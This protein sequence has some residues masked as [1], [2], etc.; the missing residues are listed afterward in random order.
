MKYAELLKNPGPPVEVDDH[1]PAFESHLF[2]SIAFLRGYVPRALLEQALAEKPDGLMFGPRLVKRDLLSVA[3]FLEIMRE[4]RRI[5]VVCRAC[6]R[7]FLDPAEKRICPACRGPLASPTPDTVAAAFGGKPTLAEKI[8]KLGRYELLETLGR[9]GMGVVYKARDTYLHRIVALKVLR[10]DLVQNAS[11]LKRFI[12]E[13]RNAARLSH[14]NIVA[15]YE[16]EELEGFHFMVMQYVEGKTLDQVLPNLSLNAKLSLL[17]RVARAVHYAHT[18]GVVHRD[19]KPQNIMVDAGMNPYVMDFGLSK[20]EEASLLL[21][22][23][24]TL[25]G[26]PAYMSPEQARGQQVDA[27]S[28]VYS[29]GVMLYEILTGTLPHQHDSM[30]TLCRMIAEQDP[31]RPRVLDSRIPADLEAVCLRALEKDRNLRYPSAQQLADDLQRFLSNEP[32]HA[33]APSSVRLLLRRMRRHRAVLV[34]F[35]TI[36]ISAAVTAGVLISTAHEQRRRHQAEQHLALAMDLLHRMEFDS[37]DPDRRHRLAQEAISQL[38]R[39]LQLYAAYAAA[40]RERG[41]GKILMGLTSEGLSDLTRAIELDP[42]S[43]LSYF[44][45]GRAYLAAYQKTKRLPVLQ[46]SPGGHFEY[47]PPKPGEGDDLRRAALD[48][49]RAASRLYS[50]ELMQWQDALARGVVALYEGKYEEARDTLRRAAALFGQSG[51]TQFYLGCTLLYLRSYQEA[52]T[53][54]SEAL[55]S[56]NPPSNAFTFRGIA[57]L[58]AWKSTPGNKTAEVLQQ[59][60]EDFARALERSNDSTAELLDYMALTRLELAGFLAVDPTTQLYRADM[61]EES[62]KTYQQALDAIDRAIA[63][64][65][66]DPAFLLHK[67]YICGSMAKL[68]RDLTRQEE[69]AQL[70]DR[71]LEAGKKD[72]Y[73]FTVAGNAWADFGHLRRDNNLDPT[74]AYRRAIDL[75]TAALELSDTSYARVTRGD[76]RLELGKWLM[77]AGPPEL[78]LF[79][80]AI[81]D[82]D[83]ACAARD[84]H[85]AWARRI[86]AEGLVFIAY[87]VRLSRGLDASPQFEAAVRDWTE[88][89]AENDRDGRAWLQLG[90]AKQFLY[91]TRPDKQLLQEAIQHY[92]RAIALGTEVA[93]A[94]RNTGAAHETLGNLREAVQHY[95]QAVALD[96]SLKP[97]LQPRIDVLKK[98]LNEF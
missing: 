29:L 73:W 94:H 52:R 44:Y 97:L 76:V 4:Q 28:D 90:I 14:P 51:E 46:L 3:Q 86:R 2:A 34:V 27:R 55:R 91:N 25:L 16:A 84:T 19:L 85:Y 1:D 31:V 92:A 18:H 6:G 43:P 8:S 48:D 37:S 20:S 11:V 36:V 13:A 53:A 45:R 66:D 17:E 83:R 72:W 61:R 62:L 56:S 24:G 41:R 12:S 23:T 63:L 60:A 49:L 67:G 57:T 26:T 54:F 82:L 35:A 50:G 74:A 10:E 21:T 89:A 33:R 64:K 58:M 88:I 59:A 9:G 22:R 78:P 77:R 95:Q 40:Y 5:Y 65:K 71:A 96:A 80:Q 39:A 7:K 87:H 47:P 42:N 30:A 81:Q 93:L 38:D 68:A 79:E 98:T 69:A 32:V 70:M 75:Y 15:V